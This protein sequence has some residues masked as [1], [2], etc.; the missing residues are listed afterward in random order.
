MSKHK[1]GFW[2]FF[3]SVQLT[4]VLLAITALISVIG[5]LVPQQEG[6]REFVRQ[7]PAGLASFLQMMQIFDL[8]HSVWFFLLM[9]LLSLN[10]IVCSANRFP[11]AWRR[12]RSPALPPETAFKNL[13]PENILQTKKDDD[14]VSALVQAA[15]KKSFRR[16]Q[17]KETAEGVVFSGTKGQIAHLGVYVVHL[18]ILIFIVGAVV[19]SL[20]G[21]EGSVNISEGETVSAIE[22]RGGKG[23]RNLPFAIRCDRFIIEFYKNGAPKTYRSDLTF[24]KNDQVAYQGPLLVNHP[25][26]FEGLRF[27][28]ASYGQ[29]PEGRA[30]L[31]ILRE[32]RKGQDVAV[33]VGDIFDLPGGEGKVHIVRIE[34]NLMK[35]GPAVKISVRSGKGEMTFWIFR[36][37]DKIKEM[38]PGII[39]QVPL[40]N[41]GL[42]QPY[43]FIMKGLEE[44]YY[45]GLQVARDPGAPLVATAAVLMIVGLMIAF[46]SAHRE[47]WMRV[48]RR[49]DKTVVRIAGRSL[50]NPAGMK[51]EMGRLIGDLRGRL[52]ME[53]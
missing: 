46:F 40:F 20:F 17:R 24:L 18:S 44:K 43:V 31:T 28:Q 26:S 25:I 4:I 53:A 9:G 13:P 39:E 1:S 37:I 49:T 35:M 33:A 22:L 5:T 47:V 29:A 41:P 16:L 45:T 11:A 34:E 7:M 21:M 30:A 42:F 48:E 14:T 19:G 8:Y 52:G 3:S 50:K 6:A 23:T 12:F 2:S 32:G 10:L 27:Y 36:H 15:M 51:R 38:N